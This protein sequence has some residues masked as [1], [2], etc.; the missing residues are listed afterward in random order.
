MVVILLITEFRFLA[1][2]VFLKI[3]RAS[4]HVNFSIII[5][6]F[7]TENSHNLHDEP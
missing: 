6:L 3:E 7:L 4:L 5:Y 2:P 1:G